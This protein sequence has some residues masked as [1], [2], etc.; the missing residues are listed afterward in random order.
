M[1]K[2]LAGDE[3]PRVRL[4]AVRA[5]SFF[6]G[7]R[8]LEILESAAG[9]PMDTPLRYAYEQA[10]QILRTRFPAPPEEPEPDA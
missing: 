9:E 8:A 4:E 10:M 5:A 3:D 7:K 2:V 6:A 1:L